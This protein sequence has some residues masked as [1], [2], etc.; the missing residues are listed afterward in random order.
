MRKRDDGSVDERRKKKEYT[1]DVADDDN[2]KTQNERAHGACE[3]I[4][5]V[6]ATK[7]KKVI[8]CVDADCK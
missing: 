8:P 5:A 1:L 6:H 3:I 7:Q 4:W 2:E